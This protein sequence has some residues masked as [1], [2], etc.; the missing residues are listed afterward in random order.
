MEHPFVIFVSLAP[1]TIN[2]PHRDGYPNGFDGRVSLQQQQF[3]VLQVLLDLVGELRADRAVD[4]AESNV[5][6]L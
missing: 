2:S 4:R 5:D 3:R 1:L 6:D